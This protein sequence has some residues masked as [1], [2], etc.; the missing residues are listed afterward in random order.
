MATNLP[1]YYKA[2]QVDNEAETEVIEVA[3]KRLALK[4]HP[5]VNK[6]PN[7]EEKM[8]LINEARK[9]LTDPKERRKYDQEYSQDNQRQSAP[10]KAKKQDVPVEDDIWEE[11]SIRN[12]AT[13][14][15]FV[16]QQALNQKKWRIA[17]EK[18]Y[19]FEGLGKPSK[20]GPLPTFT[21]FLPEWQNAKKLDELANQQSTE[22]RV[23]LQKYSFILYCT[24]LSFL[25][26]V[27]GIGDGSPGLWFLL[28]IGGLIIGFVVG[29][30]GTAVYMQWF[31]GKREEG[32][33]MFLGVM[34]PVIIALVITV[35]IYIIMG[36]AIL[37]GL[38]ISFQ[39][40]NRR[41]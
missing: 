19:A 25:G 34:T 26:L 22:F 6:S 17:Q 27:A 1:N 7:A 12:L 3:Y 11:K 28:G 9:V 21:S 5:D 40:D 2:L 8:K 29:A 24:V 32:T 33:D 36:Y 14:I 13:Q 20:D 38:S 16:V 37:K 23:K 4:Y 10:P 31:A 15:I 35:G 18:L 39:N 41:R 30:I